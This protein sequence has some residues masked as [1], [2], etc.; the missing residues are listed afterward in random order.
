M[1]KTRCVISY[2]LRKRPKNDLLIKTS[3]FKGACPIY[4]ESDQPIMVLLLSLDVKNTNLYILHAIT[5]NK[6][7]VREK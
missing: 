7:Y 2:M 3:A 5:E 6:L 1:L 4:L